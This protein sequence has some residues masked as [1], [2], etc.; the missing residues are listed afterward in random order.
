MELDQLISR[1]AVALGIGLLIGLERGWKTREVAPGHRAAGI[2]T[3][4]LCGLLG[5][6]VAALARAT[7]TPV[8]AG[9]V[10]GFGF[11]VY[12]AIFAL[13]ERDADRAAG[14]YSATTTMA[15]L[16]TFALGAYAVLGDVRAAA[17]A[18]IAATVILAVRAEIH[19]WIARITWP[20][21]R[22]AL[23]LLA[24][25]FVI[26]PVVPDTP[27]G[28]SGGVNP[29]EVWLIA[30]V[31]AAVSFL[32]YGAVRLFG[33]KRGVLL[34][35]LAGGLVSSTAVT[36]T[37]ARRAAAEEGAPVLLA[38]GVAVAT[39][40]S[41]LRVV[42]IVAVMQPALLT[43]IGPVL[44]VPTLLAIL[45]AVY[46]VHGRGAVAT[47]DKPMPAA[48]TN[49]FSFW[50]VVGFAVFLG[51]VI[52]LGHA[53]GN[54]FG[55]QGALLGA[56][57]LGL[58]DVDAVTISLARL[59]PDP[60]G[61]IAASLAILTAVTSNM[62]GKLAIAVFIDRGRFAAELAGVTV[63]CWAAGLLVL[64]GVMSLGAVSH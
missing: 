26:L 30:I 45:Y 55:A 38:A 49:P 44:G 54:A 16:L 7:G 62:V 43:M 37:N 21:L 22:S 15:G 12:A 61:P 8:G 51:A 29:R 41:F 32:G 31:L 56:A 2:R 14:S 46:A 57:G 39:A 40:V 25:T 4:A 11:A 52:M 27:I 18:A 47:D 28:P 23:V 10:L 3:F 19:G 63:V 48:F 42:A 60:L 24:M 53:V 58:A 33:A 64:W 17:A 5:G 50:P 1:L 36:L 59:V 35:A 6:I 34:S 9:L 13:L 20:E